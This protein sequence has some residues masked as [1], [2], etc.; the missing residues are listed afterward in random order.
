[1]FRNKFFYKFGYSQK[2]FFLP[3]LILLFG[4]SVLNSNIRALSDSSTHFTTPGFEEIWYRL[5]LLFEKN[6]GQRT[7]E[8]IYIYRGE[9]YDME[10]L[11]TAIVLSPKQVLAN[12]DSSLIMSIVEGSV[13]ATVTGINEEKTHINY[14]IGN[15]PSRWQTNVPTFS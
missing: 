3:F 11:T 5:P 12:G 7:T 8:A 15:E 14:L 1:M 9:T 6:T 4:I 10:F 13:Q 2:G